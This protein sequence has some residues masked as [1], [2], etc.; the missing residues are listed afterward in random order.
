LP[1]DTGQI[2]KP[3]LDCGD[4]G[5]G[6]VFVAKLNQPDKAVVQV[7]QCTEKWIYEH[8]LCGTEI[9]VVGTDEVGRGCLAGPVFAAAVVLGGVASNWVGIQDSKTLSKTNRER[10]CGVIQQHALAVG[11]AM[12]TVN[13]IEELN[14][15]HASRLAMGRAVE[16]ISNYVS[17]VLVDGLYAPAFTELR[18]WPCIPVIHGDAVCLS[19][20]AASIVAKVK[21]DAYMVE[22]AER[23]PG[24]G[25]EQNAGYGT[26]IHLDALGRLGVT[27]I[28]RRSFAPVRAVLQSNL[29]V[30]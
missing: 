29:G 10:I 4:S 25:F 23:F 26:K 2:I 1:E 16:A 20:A 13:E 9:G 30:L 18:T 5:N 27:P 28:H 8:R 14:I 19:I 12:A 22:Q 24:F 11:I 7:Q 3:P 21:R 17:V 6:D 15:L